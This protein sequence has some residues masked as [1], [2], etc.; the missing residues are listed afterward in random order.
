M[1][2]TKILEILDSE[3]RPN[4][5][6]DFDRELNLAKSKGYKLPSIDLSVMVV[7]QE[8]AIFAL[9][10]LNIDSRTDFYRAMKEFRGFPLGKGSE[11]HTLDQIIES[12]KIAYWDSEYS[13]FS[14]RFLE[15]SSIEG[16]G[17][18]FYE[19][20]TGSIYDVNWNEM[21]NFVSGKIKPLWLNFGS[22]LDWYYSEEY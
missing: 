21:D 2:S 5:Q 8:Q 17:S 18:Y 13:G 6:E 11:L 9:D 14:N 22:F 1:L 15:L 19:I 12:V 4:T 3:K 16:E 20:D 7:T 10:K